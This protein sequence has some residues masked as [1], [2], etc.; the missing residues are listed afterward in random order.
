VGLKKYPHLNRRT[1]ILSAD[2]CRCT[3]QENVSVSQLAPQTGHGPKNARNT[4]PHFFH[5]VLV[6]STLSHNLNS[7]LRRS[8]CPILLFYHNIHKLQPFNNFVSSLRLLTL[9]GTTWQLYDNI[10]QPCSPVVSISRV[11]LFS[12]MEKGTMNAGF[13]P[14]QSWTLSGTIV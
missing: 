13:A 12:V 1:T 8:F 5:D 10:I 11:F 2:I 3:G 4:P 6:V 14:Q 9:G 7:I